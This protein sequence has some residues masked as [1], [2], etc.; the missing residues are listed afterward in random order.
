MVVR[1]LIRMAFSTN[2]PSGTNQ[3][4]LK[5]YQQAAELNPKC[6]AHHVEIARVLSKMGKRPEAIST[7][8][9]LSCFGMKP[10]LLQLIAVIS[11]MGCA[12][13]L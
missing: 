1:T 7:L 3:D 8:K 9:V 11:V 5:C 13:L 6:V 10:S 2:L 12:Q 4:A